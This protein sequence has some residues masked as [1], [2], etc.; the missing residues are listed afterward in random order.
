[1]V[2]RLYD[3]LLL[4]ATPI[5][6]PYGLLKGLSYGNLWRG[7]GERFAMYDRERLRELSGR[8]VIWVH[9]VSV[10]ETR[11]SI[12]LLRQ[13]KM[14]FPDAAIVLSSLTF[15]GRSTADEIEEA[16]LCIFLPY[17][18]SFIVERALKLINPEMVLLVETEIW[19]NFIRKLNEVKIPVVMVNGRISD[20]SFPRYWLVRPLLIP[21][22]KMM[23][24]FCMQSRQD[25]LRIIRLGAA[26]DSVSVTGNL[27]FDLPA[28]GFSDTEIASFKELYSLPD[29]VP[30]WVAGSTRQGEEEIILDVY[31]KLLDAGNKLI[32]VLVPRYPDRAKTLVDLMEKHQFTFE[33][34]SSLAEKKRPFSSGE[35]L[36]GDTL[37]EMLK[38][39][40]C[41]DVVFVGGS[42]VP[43]GGH[44][45]LEAS[46]MNKAVLFGP[47]MQ[48]FK[49]ISRLLVEAGG[50]QQVDAANMAE[51]LDGLLRNETQRN[52]MGRKGAELFAA[53]SGATR[54]T[55]DTV[56]EIWRVGD[57]T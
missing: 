5:L 57:E 22:L 30:I 21:L 56:E 35:I 15:T 2:Y 54:R 49:V 45:I 23:T 16:D 1:M 27:K 28:P 52:E 36:V 51:T 20:K 47:Y 9:A 4:L 53:H 42:L 34:R 55:V 6:A 25:E 39:Y 50:G 10:G 38:F 17:D 33:L 29:D 8:K 32:L 24:C 46:L 48:N 44:N 43:I 37:G 41:A 3:I 13:L 19:P 40:A 26:S 14:R 11:A 31:S 12:P 7:L 18:L